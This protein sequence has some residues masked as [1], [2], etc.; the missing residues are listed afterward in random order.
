MSRFSDSKSIS[1]ATPRP[2]RM[3]VMFG[4]AILFNHSLEH[5]WNGGDIPD[6]SPV[7]EDAETLTGNLAHKSVP[8]RKSD[9]AA[10]AAQPA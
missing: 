1:E 4:A 5:S 9:R 6:A 10:T 2:E 8:W 3:E 7:S